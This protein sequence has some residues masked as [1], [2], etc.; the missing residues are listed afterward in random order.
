MSSPTLSLRASQMA[1]SLTDEMRHFLKTERCLNDHV[2]EIFTLGTEG[3]RITIP[4]KNIAGD[5]IDVRKYLPPSERKKKSDRKVIGL[6][7]A[8]GSP[9]IYPFEVSDLLT[10]KR[11]YDGV[12]RI[13][14]VEYLGR[15]EPLEPIY[16]QIVSWNTLFLVEGELDALALISNGFLAITNTCGAGTWNDD[17]A[18]TIAEMKIATVIC[19]DADES[20]EKG[21]ILRAE[22]LGNERVDTFVLKWPDTVSSG[23]DVTDEIKTNG[24][25]GFLSHVELATPF[26]DVISLAEVTAEDVSWLFEPYIALGKVSLVEG[27]PGI[28]KT[29][30]TLKIAAAVTLGGQGLF[31]KDSFSPSN[32]LL[33]TAEDGIGDTIKPRI[34][35]MGVNLDRVLVPRELF[36][37]DKKGFEN[38]E[39]I[40][41]RYCPLLVIIDPMMPFL[42]SKK[43]S[44]KASDMRP[45]F[46][47]LGRIADKHKCAIVVTRHLAKNPEQK[48]VTSGLGS[49]DISA[50]VRSIL[51]VSEDSEKKGLKKVFHV[52][53][54][55][56][57]KG[58]PFG[59]RLD[60]SIFTWEEIPADEESSVVLKEVERA[61]I[62][63][64]ECLG[65]GPIDASEIESEASSLGFS[66][67]TLK[68]AKRELGVVSKKKKGESAGWLWMFVKS[69]NKEAQ[70][71][72]PSQE[73]FD[74]SGCG[75][76]HE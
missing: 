31:T 56:A 16:N 47:E 72:Q 19:M 65:D 73:S 67:S 62:F 4:V 70:P 8:D 18:R 1:A 49:I 30:L 27:H 76:S 10:L 59:Y 58:K 20:G 26:R 75:E 36:T 13:E 42:D 29:F 32:V 28:G 61:M 54:N 12:E 17:F 74:V 50:A 53:S 2:I 71:V 25:E 63:L 22:S 3:N 46:K 15:L 11:H 37:L 7:D 9:K 60:D 35:Q 40:I 44:N 33:M 5:V 45:F 41:T 21:A 55:I 34:E 66:K 48:G 51:Q 57:Q 69:R 6:A 24:I 52:K 39:N 64:E 38:L 14:D 23:H 43:D 68:R